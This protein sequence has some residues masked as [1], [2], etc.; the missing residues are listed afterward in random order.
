ML[1]DAD[2][3]LSDPSSRL[4]STRVALVEFSM[5]GAP[6]ASGVGRR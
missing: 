6:H 5:F 1:D 3:N 2:V 4:A